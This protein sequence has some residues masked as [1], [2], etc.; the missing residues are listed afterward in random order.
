MADVRKMRLDKRYLLSGQRLFS[1]TVFDIH[2]K[3][4]HQCRE[5]DRYG[6]DVDGFFGY[7]DFQRTGYQKM[8]IWVTFIGQPQPVAHRVMPVRK[9]AISETVE[10]S[11]HYPRKKRDTQRP[12]I[13]PT[14]RRND[15]PKHIEEDEGN[16]KDEKENVDNFPKN[17]IF[18][19]S[20]ARIPV[21]QSRRNI[22]PFVR[23]YPIQKVPNNE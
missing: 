6:N 12:Q 4:D 7:R 2:K 10:D 21:W 19:R 5:E 16:V 22:I 9:E 8:N 20:P 1:T 23:R 11:E 17:H 3:T 18:Y 13:Q 15:P 14:P